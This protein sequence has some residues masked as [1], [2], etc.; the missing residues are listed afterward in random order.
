MLISKNIF[1]R[2]VSLVILLISVFFLFIKPRLKAPVQPSYVVAITQFAHHPSLDEIRRGIT[3]ILEKSELPI[4]IVYQNAQMT[5]PLTT[6][7]ADHFL[8]LNPSVAVAITTPSAQALYRKLS[9]HQIPVVFSGVSDPGVAKLVDISKKNIRQNL[10]YIT[11]VADAPPLKQQVA[12]IKK[13]LPAVKKIGMI[14]NAGEANSTAILKELKQVL[15]NNG[16][17]L[18]AVSVMTASDVAQAAMKLI[19]NIDALYVSND[20]LVVSSLDSILKV[21]NHE[22]VPIFSSDDSSVKKGCLGAVALNQYD[23]GTQT[24]HLI[25]RILKG[26]TLNNIPWENVQNEQIYI[27]LKAAK[28]LSILIPQH[29]LDDPQ[30]HLMHAEDKKFNKSQG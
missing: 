12:F 5:I 23:I 8:S 27:N 7:I 20:N 11:G 29:L 6:Q 30:V 13:I 14:Y 4:K 28:A 9:S 1:K 10:P 16:I 2:L 19:K 15:E 21:F 25:I 18:V 26:E 22:K 24:A 17:K 3:D